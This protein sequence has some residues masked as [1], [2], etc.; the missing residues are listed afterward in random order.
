[1]QHNHNPNFLITHKIFI[2]N[3]IIPLLLILFTFFNKNLDSP[4]ILKFNNQTTEILITKIGDK[5]LIFT[6]VNFSIIY[7]NSCLKF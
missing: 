2:I 3:L 1:M 7:K 5:N 4:S 6:N